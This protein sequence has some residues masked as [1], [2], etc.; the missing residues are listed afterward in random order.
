MG[1]GLQMIVN[2]R[3]KRGR[4]A[5]VGAFKQA[6][7]ANDA[8]MQFYFVTGRNDYVVIY[9]AASMEDYDEFIESI[10]AIDPNLLTETNVVI[11]VLKA[12]LSVPIPPMPRPEVEV[13]KARNGHAPINLDQLDLR[14]LRAL[15]ERCTLTAE[16]LAESCGT[17]PSTAL[18]RLHRFRTSGVI[19]REVAL[20]DATKI[21][22]GLLL[23]VAVRLEREDGPAV[24]EFVERVSSHPNVQQFYFVTGTSDYFIIF[25]AGCM[26]EYDDF[27]KANLVRDPVVV[28]SNTNVVIRPLK[29]SLAFPI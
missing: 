13:P 22:R 8:V 9:A 24:E 3:T 5:D 10:L 19:R 16:E 11:R 23:M 21:G 29:A 20:V 26:E 6:M 7:L 27:L 14:L 28:M 17:S 18:R 2:V 1:R 15:Q 4:E 12:G 25:S